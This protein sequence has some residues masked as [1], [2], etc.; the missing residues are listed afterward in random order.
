MRLDVFLYENG[1]A[2]SRTYAA[3]LIKNSLVSVDGVIVD[4]PSYDT[5]GTGVKVLGDLYSFVGRGGVKLDYALDSF[6][7]DV[8][9]KIALDIGAS[10][11]GFTDCLLKRGAKAVYALDSGHGQLDVSLVNDPRVVNIEG[12]NAKD[13]SPSAF[14]NVRFDIA[15]CDVSFIS[16]T[17]F[18]ANLRTVLADNSV[19]I[20]LIKPQFE[21]GR[22]ALGKNGIV[23]DKR[24]HLEAI[25][26]VVA[27]AESADLD[28]CRIVR[29]PISGGDGNTEFLA[30]FRTGFKN[31]ADIAI[32]KEAAH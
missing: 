28:F 5:D 22:A 10:T 11:G 25:K 12:F 14:E 26:K 29:S 7:I 6:K 2:K 1:M 24:F 31:E 8:K 17:I 19:F 16:Q 4:K 27:S 21:C 18:L 32:L 20:T 23:R 13:I 15:V 30:M 9:E 3:E